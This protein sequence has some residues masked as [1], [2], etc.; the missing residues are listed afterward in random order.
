MSRL[1]GAG[2]GALAKHLSVGVGFDSGIVPMSRYFFERDH[3]VDIIG[4]KS[5][6]V[7]RRLGTY[8]GLLSWNSMGDS[9]IIELNTFRGEDRKRLL[10]N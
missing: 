7:S 3:R 6:L 2:G 1:P 10:S 9:I 5:L 4:A 8:S